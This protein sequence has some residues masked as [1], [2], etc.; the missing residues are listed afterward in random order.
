M[1]FKLASILVEIIFFD[2]P[3]T[4]I[5]HPVFMEKPFK[6]TFLEFYKHLIEDKKFRYLL[7]IITKL[8]LRPFQATQTI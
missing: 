6:S 5:C 4:F 8:R 2:K 7:A 1:N 3:L